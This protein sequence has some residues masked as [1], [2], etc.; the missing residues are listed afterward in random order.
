MR[1]VG[2]NQGFEDLLGG[3]ADLAGDGDGGQ[4]VFIDLVFAK[5]EG[6][7][8]R[9]E[10]AGGVGLHAVGAPRSSEATRPAFSVITQSAMGAASS[11]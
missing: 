6:D 9:L 4:I 3:H 1:A 7:I 2:R 8:K 11:R 10:I 5:L